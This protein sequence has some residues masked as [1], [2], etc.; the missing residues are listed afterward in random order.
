MAFKISTHDFTYLGA[1]IIIGVAVLT[2]IGNPQIAGDGSGLITRATFD[3]GGGRPRGQ[4]GVLNGQNQ[5]QMVEF[6]LDTGN[7]ITLI[8]VGTAQSLNLPYQQGKPFSVLGVGGAPKT[9]MMLE[10]PIKIGNDDP[11]VV[12]IGVGDTPENLLG[13]Q[14]I[15]PQYRIVYDKNRQV[16]FQESAPYPTRIAISSKH[17]SVETR[18]VDR[19]FWYY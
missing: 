13:Y 1:G 8:T 3:T 9:F 19:R 5:F 16:L 10:R 17:D 2:L 14:D 12:K 4:I 6:L 11:I 15:A 7:D 18:A